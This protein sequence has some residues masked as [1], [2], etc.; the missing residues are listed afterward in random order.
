MHLGSKE[1]G[2][3]GALNTTQLALPSAPVPQAENY[4]RSPSLKERNRITVLVNS[5]A[6]TNTMTK[7]NLGER[8]FLWLILPGHRP[9]LTSEQESRSSSKNRS[10]EHGGTLLPGLFSG[11]LSC[12]SY[13]TRTP[14]TQRWYH[15][16]G[17]HWYQ[18]LGSPHHINHKSRQSLTDMFPGHPDCD[19]SSTETPA[20]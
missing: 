4:S 18:L 17:I 6:G 3:G 7:S 11:L 10:R 20:F 9:S 12:L 14:L 13:I 19:N 1:P 8:R 15:H 5:I 2:F 16:Y